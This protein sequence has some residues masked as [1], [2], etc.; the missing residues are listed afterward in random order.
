MYK[1]T[2][3]HTNLHTYTHTHIVKM[4][5][6]WRSNCFPDQGLQNMGVSREMRTQYCNAI[7]PLFIMEII[8]SMF[9]SLLPRLLVELALLG[10]QEVQVNTFFDS[11]RRPKMDHFFYHSYQNNGAEQNQSEQTNTTLI[12]KQIKLKG[13]AEM[14][15]PVSGICP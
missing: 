13:T 6:E 4:S 8:D 5:D 1:H 10:K 9:V 7:E 15:G 2:Y 11:S 3:K 12:E 14:L